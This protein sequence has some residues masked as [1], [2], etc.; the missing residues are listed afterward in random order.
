MEFRT[1][2]FRA[3]TFLNIRKWPSFRNNYLYRNPYYSAGDINLITANE[4]I[5]DFSSVS[6]IIISHISN[7][8]FLMARQRQWA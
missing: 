2:N 6:N 4:N 3:L 5:D 8:F 7:F 1:T